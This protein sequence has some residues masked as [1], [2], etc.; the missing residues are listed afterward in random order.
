M[1]SYIT[2]EVRLTLRQNKQ[3][4][5]RTSLVNMRHVCSTSARVVNA[6]KKGCGSARKN[7]DT[8]L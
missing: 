4:S 2:D 3:D 7:K 8:V 6:Q 5:Q 1:G